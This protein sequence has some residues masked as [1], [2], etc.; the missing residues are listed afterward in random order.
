MLPPPVYSPRVVA[1]A[2]L[3]CAQKHV[4]DLVVGGGGKAI[5]GMGRAARM[6]DRYMEAMLFRQQ[7]GERPRKLFRR[8]ALHRPRTDGEERGD[9]PGY[10]M[11]T[12]AY[13][14]ARLH[15]VRTALAVAALGAGVALALG[16]GGERRGG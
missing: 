2:I 4:R 9:H 14:A 8:D 11:R 1:R 10:V 12:S 3:H 15:P 13:T 7:K 16:R 6:A 5:S